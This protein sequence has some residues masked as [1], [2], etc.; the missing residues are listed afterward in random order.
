MSVFNKASL[1][2]VS[3]SPKQAGKSAQQ[4]ASRPSS[5]MRSNSNKAASNSNLKEMLAAVRASTLTM[6]RQK[7]LLAEQKRT[8][9]IVVD[10][11]SIKDSIGHPDLRHHDSSVLSIH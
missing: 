6:E 11:E 2:L 10:H 9:V 1:A 4:K 7:A 8:S 5:S 3:G